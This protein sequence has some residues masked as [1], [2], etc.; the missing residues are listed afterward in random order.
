MWITLYTDA[1]YSPKDGGGWGV[2]IRSERGRIVRRGKCPPYVR[3]SGAAELSAIYAGVHIALRAWGAEVQ[4]VFVRSDSQ[5]AL[6]RA[7]PSTPL[8]RDVATRRLQQ[9][10]RSLLGPSIELQTRWVK[11]HQGASRGTAAYLNTAVDRL[12]RL[13]RTRRPS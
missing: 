8:A 2:W 5:E 7:T 13:G 11:G 3:S 10:L 1:S 9:K 12:A 6:L 4:G